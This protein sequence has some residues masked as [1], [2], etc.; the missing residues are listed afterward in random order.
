MSY[1]TTAIAWWQTNR[2]L[3]DEKVV[4]GV[5]FYGYTNTTGA[6]GISFAGII[7]TYGAAAANQDTWTSGGNTIYYNGIPTI[8]AKTQLG[9]E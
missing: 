4:L 5:P 2:A 9:R 7:N 1:A 3:P 6:G 8:R